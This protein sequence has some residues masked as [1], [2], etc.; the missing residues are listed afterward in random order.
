MSAIRKAYLAWSHPLSARVSDAWPPGEYDRDALDYFSAKLEE[1]PDTAGW[2]GWYVLSLG[3]DG[4][5]Q[6]V[7]AG[8]GYL[9]PPS[10]DGVIELEK[11]V[12][13]ALPGIRLTAATQVPAAIPVR[14]G[15][16]Y[17]AVEPRGALYERMLK[18]Q[19][20][21]VYV[22]SS[23]RELKLELLAILQ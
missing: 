3:T 2:Y 18:A 17:F 11:I 15:S 13:S 8:A 5:R 19:A 1:A 9:G 21:V 14:P 10:P 12:V 4:S 6:S 16:Y 20:V 7:V 23:F 22:P